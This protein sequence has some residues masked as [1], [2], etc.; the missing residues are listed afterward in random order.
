MIRTQLL[1]DAVASTTVARP[2]ADPRPWALQNMPSICCSPQA[3]HK[4]PYGIFLPPAAPHQQGPTPP[5]GTCHPQLGATSGP[6]AS[7]NPPFV[8][9][10]AHHR[11]PTSQHQH[12]PLAHA[13]RQRLSGLTTSRL[14]PTLWHMPPTGTGGSPLDSNPPLWYVLPTS[15][16][17]PE[18]CE[19]WPAVRFGDSDSDRER[20]RERERELDRER[21]RQ[22]QRQRQR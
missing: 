17:C 16:R 11:L 21:Q 3:R 22:R 19:A 9:Y 14:N 2:M 20:E 8:A 18:V 4:P 15:R 6:P 12:S 7:L 1:S 5:S 10:D 13:A